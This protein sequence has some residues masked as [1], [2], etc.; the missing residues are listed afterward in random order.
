MSIDGGPQKPA[1][2]LTTDDFP[3]EW[4]SDN[5]S[6]FVQ[7]VNWVPVQVEKVDLVSGKREKVPVL[8]PPDRAGLLNIRVSDILNDGAGYAYWAWKQTSTL[9]VVH[10]VK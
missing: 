8:G 5:R 6:V 3:I 2:G 10:G 4:A 1:L 7:N 9:F